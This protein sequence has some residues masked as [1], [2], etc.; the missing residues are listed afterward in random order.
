MANAASKEH[1][2]KIWNEWHLKYLQRF[3]LR[4][5]LAKDVASSSLDLDKDADN[6]GG[7][8]CGPRVSRVCYML[9]NSPR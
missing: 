8:E 3:D 6:V 5:Q 1:V 7:R 9:I 2:E 4:S